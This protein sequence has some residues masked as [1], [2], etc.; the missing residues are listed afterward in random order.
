MNKKLKTYYCI[1]CSKK[2]QADTYLYGTKRCQ[3]CATKYQW[4]I[5]PNFLKGKNSPAYI[6]GRTNE[7]HYC[8]DCGKEINIYALRCKKCAK[9]GR[10]HPCWIDGRSYE[11]Y[12]SEFNEELKESIRK[13]DNYECQNCSM[14]EEEHLIVV[15]RVLDVHHIDYNKMNCKEENLITLCKSCNIRANFN[16]DYWQEFYNRKIKDFFNVIK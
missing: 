3:S 14:T 6:D 11:P 8:I 9:Q 10:K 7:K 12:T 5:N 4:K 15:G 16:R 13:R 2:I 1:D